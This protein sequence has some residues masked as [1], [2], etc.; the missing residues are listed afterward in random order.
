MTKRSLDTL[1]RIAEG[2]TELPKEDQEALVRYVN[3]ADENDIPQQ[4]RDHQEFLRDARMANEAISLVQFQDQFLNDFE[5]F[6]QQR[7]QLG[8]AKRLPGGRYELT[9]E[10]WQQFEPYKEAMTEQAVQLGIKGGN[11][12]AIQEHLDKIIQNKVERKTRGWD[13]PRPTSSSGSGNES[14]TWTGGI[15]R[16]RSAGIIEEGA[17]NPAFTPGGSMGATLKKADVERKP[18]GEIVSGRNQNMGPRSFVDSRGEPVTLKPR[19]IVNDG[20]GNLYVEGEVVGDGQV[21]TF[22]TIETDENGNEKEVTK[23]VDTSKKPETIT[24]SLRGNESTADRYFDKGWNEGFTSKKMGGT[25][26][27]PSTSARSSD[28]SIEDLLKL[29]GQ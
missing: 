11:R 1:A 7:I 17:P 22:T 5:Q 6:A 9:E 12:E 29:Y 13:A 23:T 8:K 18:V 14:R 26:Q 3:N 15:E 24:L 21:V 19:H 2:K 25:S 4:G 20:Y 16:G 10:E 27:R 28:S